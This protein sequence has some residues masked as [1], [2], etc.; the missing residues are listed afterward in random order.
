M[1]NEFNQNESCKLKLDI[2]G[3]S[4]LLTKEDYG[5]FLEQT[6]NKYVRF[7]GYLDNNL[8]IKKLSEYHIL[9]LPTKFLGEGTPGVISESLIAG[10]PIV[11][12]SFY[13][14]KY[15]V[16]NGFDGVIYD[17]NDFHTLY[18]TLSKLCLDKKMLFRLHEG[19]VESGKRFTY[20]AQ[21]EYF[22]SF[23]KDN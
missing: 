10:T 3:D 15:I 2:Y 11:C 12:S 7:L 13:Q 9:C 22:L 19:A 17:I 6:N 14:S 8:V 5:L 4:R 20:K 23:F 18:K 16:K 21:R 1:V